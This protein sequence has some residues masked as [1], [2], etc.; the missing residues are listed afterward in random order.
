[1][2][3]LRTRAKRLARALRPTP[4]GS[5]DKRPVRTEAAK[6]TADKPTVGMDPLD[7]LYEFW[8]Q[9]SPEGNN[10]EHYLLPSGRSRALLELISDLPKDAHILEVGCNVGRNLAHLYDHGYTNLAGV[11]INPHAVELL[12][13]RFPQLATVPVHL[14]PARE[15]LS[16]M[17]SDSFDLVYTMAVIEHIHPDESGVF[18]DMVRIGRQILAIEPRRGR[19]SH[20]QF[21][22]D[23]PEVFGSR[24]MEMVSARSMADI[25]AAAQDKTIH[26]FTAY[27]FNRRPAAV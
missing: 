25:P 19:S 4:V 20:R 5:A 7:K 10:P 18:D 2:L 16:K 26:A 23:V 12:R 27:R 24:G 1:M 8:R 15:L 3:K 9:P 22:H 6:P 21:P 11:E 13:Q 17:Q 14:G